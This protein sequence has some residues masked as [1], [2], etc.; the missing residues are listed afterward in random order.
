[1]EEDFMEV[2]L[3]FY[4]DLGVISASNLA[5]SATNNLI[6]ISAPTTQHQ[7]RISALIHANS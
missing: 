4:L 1:M 3:K 5:S 2:I 6:Q 7:A